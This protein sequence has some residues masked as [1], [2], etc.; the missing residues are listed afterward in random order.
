MN[1]SLYP[2]YEQELR[3]LRKD[4]EGFAK[5]YPAAAGRLLLDASQSADPHV[6]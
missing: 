2:Y 5:S 1:R 3:F 6:E 4:L